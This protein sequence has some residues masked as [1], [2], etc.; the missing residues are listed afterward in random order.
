MFPSVAIAEKDKTKTKNMEFIDSAIQFHKNNAQVRDVVINNLYDSYNGIVKESLRKVFEKKFGKQISTQF[1]DYKLGHAKIK[2][3]KGEFLNLEFSPTVSSINPDILDKR[4]DFA[5][6]I[7]GASSMK[8]FLDALKSQE[9]IDP[10]NGLEVPKEDDPSLQDRMFPKTANE[11]FMQL[12]INEKIESQN[13]K[14][15]GQGSFMDLII[16][17]EC[18]GVI[19]KDAYGEDVFRIINPKD[20]V[21]QESTDDSFAPESPFKGER[22]MM[23][24]KDICN[25]YPD[26]SDPDKAKLNEGFDNFANQDE[27]G[28]RSING[29][30]AIETY[31]I[32]WKEIREVYT[33]VSKANSGPDYRLTIDNDDYIK[34][35]SK[36]KRD[37]NSGKY[38]I[39]VAYHDDLFQ[40]TRIGEDIYTNVGRT[41]SQVHRLTK[42]N[43]YRAEYDYVN[44]LFGT[45]DGV[46]MSLQGLISGLS[47]VNN[48]IM[49]MIVRELK[50][51]KGKVIVYDEALR[52][53]LKTMKNIFYDIAEDG[54]LTINS[55][56]DGNFS[57]NDVQNAVN[58]IQELDLGLSDSFNLL[59][60]L[61]ND[62]SNTLDRITGINESR[63]GQSPVS[64]TATGTL[65]NIEASRS[66]TR[67]LFYGHQIFMNKVFSILAEKTK[68][69]KE[70]L[71]SNRAK[72]LLGDTGIKFIKASKELM[73][74]DF[75][76]KFTD[77]GKEREIR[78]RIARFFDVEIN[79]GNLRTQD[80]IKFDMTKNLNEGV[81]VLQ[82]AWD[83]INN[84]KREEL[85]NSNQQQ[86]EA[87]TAGQELAKE[88]REDLQAHEVE[89]ERMKIES[90]ERV[91]GFKLD[92]KADAD[93]IKANTE[94]T[95]IQ[96]QKEISSNKNTN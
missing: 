26:L 79:G 90:K 27:K 61:K 28:F 71:D 38:K 82:S 18:H 45:I 52:P 72:I 54:V 44:F 43:K 11:I 62:I 53:K 81:R 64:Q 96:S 39:E 25:T 16:A 41:E 76:V 12:I 7:K 91:E 21:F 20:A 89:I 37:V 86:Q 47:E 6:L 24:V 40:G 94:F 56:G 59:L 49:H 19:E 31:T 23:Y 83:E 48:I 34:N 50:K 68:L 70:Y 22:R 33:K 60:N 2:L 8:R 66:I 4:I 93:D 5:N 92:Q 9:G 1:L 10:L 73:F 17:S 42:N 13:L 57:G 77:G 15:K 58:L 75:D 74:D 67:D 69:N 55:S 65:Q 51:I 32:Q 30:P 46:R 3:L 35:E 14:L 29:I 87:L 36:Y 84:I 63:E 78:D 85:Q 95:K 80:V 88:N